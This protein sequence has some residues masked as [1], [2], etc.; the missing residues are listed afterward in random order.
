MRCSVIALLFCLCACASDGTVRADHCALPPGLNKEIAK[1][2]PDRH[3]EQMSDLEDY[4]R[5][6]FRKDHGERCPG[7]V[8]VNFYGD[9]KPTWALVLTAGEHPKR[10]VT[11]LV[12]RQ[13]ADGWELRTLA[14]TD[15]EP[16]VWREGPGKYEGMYEEEGEP[17]IA[18]HPVIIFCDYGSSEVLYA[19]TGS[20]V[21]KIWLSD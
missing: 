15:G 4:D 19:W 6:L 14:E 18:K 17:L 7:L 20:E 1:Q 16:V 11:L 5:K 10:K 12:A 2:F 3:V 13:A 21:K 8:R 9:G